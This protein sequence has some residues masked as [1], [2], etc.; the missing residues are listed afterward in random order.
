MNEKGGKIIYINMSER[1]AEARGYGVIK[2][3]EDLLDVAISMQIAIANA[4][5]TLGFEFGDV[6]RSN[7]SGEPVYRMRF[8]VSLKEE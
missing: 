1:V 4:C 3:P 7:E 6:T 8:Q 2:Q 5:H